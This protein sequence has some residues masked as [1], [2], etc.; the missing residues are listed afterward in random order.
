MAERTN[1]ITSTDLTNEERSTEELRRDIAARRESIT[2]TVDKLSERV[3]RTLDWREYVSEHPVAS[4]G[5]AVGVGFL[6]SGIFKPRP[7][8]GE[9]I[10]D[11]LSETVEDLGNRFRHQLD[12]LPAKRVGPGR[13]VKAALTAMVTKSITD[14][15]TGQVR[16]TYGARQHS[17]LATSAPSSAWPSTGAATAETDSAQQAEPRTRFPSSKSAAT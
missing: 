9:R 16:N 2:E 11:A 3:Q 8:P 5:I 4:L 14:Y 12:A 10:M 17:D 13:T 15:I 1:L 6:V 7:T